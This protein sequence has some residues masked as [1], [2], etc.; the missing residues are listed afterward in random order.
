MNDA[1]LTSLLQ[2]QRSMIL[3]LQMLFKLQLSVINNAAV[4]FLL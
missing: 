4:A 2:S 1:A 3:Q